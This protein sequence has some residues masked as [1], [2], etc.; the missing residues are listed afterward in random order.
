M[1]SGFRILLIGNLK[2]GRQG[3]IFMSKYFISKDELYQLYFIQNLTTKQIA[4]KFNFPRADI[5]VKL[6]KKY[7]FKC[8]SKNEIESQRVMQ[9]M[10]DEEFKSYLEQK[11]QTMSIKKI[12]DEL[13]VSGSCIAKYFK[14]YS[15]NGKFGNAYRQQVTMLGMNDEEFK[16]FLIEQ[17]SSK[18]IN[19]IAEEL[20]VSPSIIYKYMDKYNIPRLNHLESCKRYAD[21]KPIKKKKRVS[22]GD[23]Y[24]KLYMPW[25]YRANQDGYVLEHIALAEQKLNRRL[26][27]DE[28]VH[29]INGIKNDNSLDNL[30]VL[31]KEEHRNIHRNNDIVGG[32]KMRSVQ[33]LKKEGGYNE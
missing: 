6:M 20:N 21:N 31:T 18:S 22:H 33:Q 11:S 2:H 25:H 28:V 27:P 8:R 17:Y 14:K 15:I 30:V 19:K 24:I 16:T 32:N 3:V 23:G 26:L 1:P 7:D 10:N 4:E 12:A 9:G 29:H 13:N 5:V